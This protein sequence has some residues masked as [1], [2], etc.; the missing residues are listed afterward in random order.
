MGRA[1][2]SFIEG[3]KSSNVPRMAPAT[4][5]GL[6][7]FAL[8]T[9]DCVSLSVSVACVYCLRLHLAGIACVFFY[10]LQRNFEH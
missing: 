2:S 10:F 9:R 5:A 1:R 4:A 7:M 6:I 3:P 8:M